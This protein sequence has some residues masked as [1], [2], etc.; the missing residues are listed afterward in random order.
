MGY[1]RS[2]IAVIPQSAWEPL[3]SGNGA[4]LLRCKSCTGYADPTATHSDC[5]IRG[6][7]KDGYAGACK[8]RIPRAITATPT[9][10]DMSMTKNNDVPGKWTPEEDALLREFA[11]EGIAAVA[12]RL[13]RTPNA[14]QQRACK[15]G[16]SLKRTV[17]APVTPVTAASA[18]PEAIRHD[19]APTI[20]EVS[21]GVAVDGSATLTPTVPVSCKASI[22]VDAPLRVN[23]TTLPGSL[24]TCCNMSRIPLCPLRELS[25][26]CRAGAVVEWPPSVDECITAA[27]YARGEMFAE[28]A[29]RINE[30][31]A[32]GDDASKWAALA[33]VLDIPAVIRDAEL[34]HEADEFAE[35]VT[36]RAQLAMALA[37]VMELRVELMMLALR[38]KLGDDA[39][40]FAAEHL[41]PLIEAVE[42]A[43]EVAM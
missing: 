41:W 28:A 4:A 5:T 37:E 20:G 38:D 24:G 13:G 2:S 22:G 33:Y 10:E 39:T 16:V 36:V 21:T 25:G 11:H 7:R 32:M 26:A 43:A 40:G 3:L 12:E 31:A 1:E 18:I 17:A 6:I 9:R 27:D 30:A 29:A 34:E 23:L 19:D 42:K 8:K 15:V 35:A 14:I